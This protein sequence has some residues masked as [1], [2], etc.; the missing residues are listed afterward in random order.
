MNWRHHLRLRNCTKSA[1]TFGKNIAQTGP[2]D[3]I[4]IQSAENDTECEQVVKLV[5][6]RH[7]DSLLNRIAES[8][9]GWFWY[10]PVAV[11]FEA[12]Y[13]ILRLLGSACPSQPFSTSVRTF[14]SKRCSNTSSERTFQAQGK[15]C[16]GLPRCRVAYT[17]AKVS[18]L[19]ENIH[20]VSQPR[21]NSR[22]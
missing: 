8:T 13:L 11:A 17:N 4:G 15:V 10:H 16:N 5:K 2:T 19:P 3:L 14:V 12:A 20:P 21:I 22:I 18:N 7:V 9:C 1:G 6:S